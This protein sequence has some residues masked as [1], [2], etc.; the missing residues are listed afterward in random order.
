MN[1]VL[2][3]NACIALCVRQ[4]LQFPVFIYITYI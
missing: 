4:N 3:M 1:I 2:K